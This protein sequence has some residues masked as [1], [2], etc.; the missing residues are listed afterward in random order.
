VNAAFAEF[1]VEV[2]PVTEYAVAVY[3]F[4]PVVLNVVSAFGVNPQD[5]AAPV[6]TGTYK[7]HVQ[8]A[9]AQPEAQAVVPVVMRP[10][11]SEL[12]TLPVAL[13]LASVFSYRYQ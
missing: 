12:I 3:G 2:R 11:Q 7:A 6:V 13:R 8:S 9:F 1:V 4:V 10:I 5:P